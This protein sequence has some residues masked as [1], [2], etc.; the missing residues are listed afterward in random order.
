MKILV[1]EDNADS[2]IYLE[3]ILK[4]SGYDAESAEN[5]RVAWDKARC[6]P[7]DL[8]ISDI[9]MPEV[10]GFALCRQ[11]KSDETLREIPFIF[12]TAT[13]TDSQD[14]ALALNLGADRFVIKPQPPEVMLRI[15]REVLDAAGDK[16]DSADLSRDEFF[17][18]YNSALFRKLEQK[19]RDLEQEVAKRTKIEAAVLRDA[20]IARQ[21]QEALLAPLPDTP[22]VE[23][24]TVYQP[25]LYVGGDLYYLD[26]RQDGK[27]LRGFLFTAMG[28]GMSRALYAAAVHVML[29]EIS[30]SDLPLAEQVRVLNRRV[31]QYFGLGMVTRGIAF[32]LDLET[33]QLRWVNAGIN[34]FW[35]AGGI[36][37]GLVEHAD[38]SA[39]NYPEDVLT[40]QA[41]PI[42][43]GDAFY[44]CTTRAA[45]LLSAQ[46]DPPLT[47][48]PAMVE[49][50]RLASVNAAGEPQDVLAVCLR[51]RCLPERTEQKGCWPRIFRFGNYADY[52]RFRGEIAKVLADA[53]GLTHS[54]PEVAVNEALAN[55]LECRDGVARPHQVRLRFNAL[56]TRLIVRV[57]STRLG[58]AGNA[59]LQRL[60]AHPED[61]FAF[62]GSE[63]M[64]RGIPLM[65]SLSDKMVY[66]SDG[67]EVLLAWR[68]G[69]A[70]GRQ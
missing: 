2:R 43:S 62:G 47:Q 56:G 50:L 24:A 30:D 29:R 42:V 38:F 14:E 67:T 34:K 17:A 61:M 46:S 55:A 44:F 12:Y 68:L 32:E 9:L 13:Y 1:A 3:R 48:F 36:N 69:E 57:K 19:V 37:A 63:A 23:T 6:S 52:Q 65:L 58:F 60:K 39:K 51:V 27:L 45:T 16:A 7:P 28:Q 35:L 70:A 15:I 4:N 59:V 10:D 40:T 22:F 5:G 26:W 31:R 11:W 18:Q 33:R 21:L 8:V 20:E 49:R 53:T 25:G 64:G 41:L 66:N 54:F